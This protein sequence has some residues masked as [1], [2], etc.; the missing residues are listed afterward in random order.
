VA[1]DL[2]TLADPRFRVNNGTPRPITVHQSLIDDH[3]DLLVRFLAVTLRAAD[4]A[5]QYPERLREILTF[6]TAGTD[7]AVDQAYGRL[8]EGCT[9]PWTKTG[10]PCSTSR[11]SSSS[12][13]AFSM[14]ISRWP[15]GWTRARW[16]RRWH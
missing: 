13:M 9:R 12:P 3:F 1:I 11:R 15:T 16:R 2:D 8:H 14:R 4:W 10:W 7:E 5:V 6:E